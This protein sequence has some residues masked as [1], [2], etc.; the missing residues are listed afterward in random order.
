MEAFSVLT[1]SVTVTH[2]KTEMSHSWKVEVFLSLHS[3]TEV[4][5]GW[6]LEEVF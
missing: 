5:M 2:R 1:Q 3:S 6:F 4:S